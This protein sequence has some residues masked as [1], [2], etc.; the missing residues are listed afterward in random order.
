MQG[1]GEQG[2]L[3]I[4]LG[5]VTE[6]SE[7][8]SLWCTALYIMPPVGVTSQLRVLAAAFCIMLLHK[9]C[10]G[11]ELT[12]ALVGSPLSSQLLCRK[13]CPAFNS[14]GHPLQCIPKHIPLSVSL[15]LS[16]SFSLSLCVCAGTLLVHWGR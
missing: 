15:S 12:P 10:E 13:L 16:L 9:M 1:A 4:A 3:L 14:M 6:M 8:R 7:P 5:T 11:C 2:V